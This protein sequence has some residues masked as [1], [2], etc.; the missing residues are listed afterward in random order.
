MG[1]VALPELRRYKYAPSLAT[2]T[3]DPLPLIAA[4]YPLEA[5][6]AAMTHAAEPGV[7]KVLLEPTT[8]R[9]R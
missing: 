1:I 5:S 3:I 9:N 6:L 2:G 4:R 8:T 7:L